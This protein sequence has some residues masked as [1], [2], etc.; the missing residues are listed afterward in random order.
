MIFSFAWFT[1]DDST[2]KSRT[3]QPAAGA[4][5]RRGEEE[6]AL[7]AHA[8]QRRQPALARRLQADVRVSCRR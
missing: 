1:S 4:A 3:F 8:D 6:A 5:D 2:S 7:A